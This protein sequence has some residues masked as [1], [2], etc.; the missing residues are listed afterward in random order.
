ML[1]ETEE[2]SSPTGRPDIWRAIARFSLD[3]G[4]LTL[5]RRLHREQY[6]W[7]LDYSERV[8]EEY[9]RFIYLTAVSRTPVTPSDQVD[10][11]WH[12]HILYMENYRDFT[13]SCLGRILYHGPTK[14]GV[15]EVK[16]FD[17]QY[18]DTLELYAQEFG[19]PPPADIWPDSETRF[20][21]A[22][23][24]CWVCTKRYLVVDRKV[25][26]HMGLLLIAIALVLLILLFFA[27]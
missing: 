13:E 8:V 2:V 20:G 6:D 21:N 16:R 14:G 15:K 4:T 24:L 19:H 18:R 9:R 1:L 11:A 27:L 25:L 17:T 3:I 22:E 26:R 7:S 12:L 5:T 23:D 10:Q